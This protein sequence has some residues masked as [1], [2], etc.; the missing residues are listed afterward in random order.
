MSASDQHSLNEYE[1]FIQPMDEY[2]Q[3]LLADVH[4]RDWVNPD[5]ASC[6]ELVVTGAGTA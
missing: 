1:S 5:P 4:P 6:H 2:N 3:S